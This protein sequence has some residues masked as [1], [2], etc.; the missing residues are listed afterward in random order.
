LA[1]TVVAPIVIGTPGGQ[2]G[3]GGGAPR[4][5]LTTLAVGAT[6]VPVAEEVFFR[7]VLQ[8][9]LAESL[10]EWGAIG[11][12]SVL[13]T[14]IHVG[15]FAAT[16]TAVGVGLAKVFGSALLLGYVYNRTRNLTLTVIAHSGFN[17]LVYGLSYLQAVG[18]FEGNPL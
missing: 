3:S 17:A 5:I 14:A 1:T 18:L 13:F 15:N 9:R 16:P 10:P 2:S 11:G 8:K 12:S 7:N 4:S 6:L